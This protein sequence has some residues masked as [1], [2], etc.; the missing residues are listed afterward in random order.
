MFINYIRL[1]KFSGWSRIHLRMDNLLVSVSLTECL[2]LYNKYLLSLQTVL[3]ELNVGQF[4]EYNFDYEILYH[5]LNSEGKFIFVTMGVVYN[6]SRINNSLFVKEYYT[7]HLD[8][9]NS[10]RDLTF[11]YRFRYHLNLKY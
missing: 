2:D 8:K 4:L 11:V 7:K 6:G 9:L 5:G 3:L 10:L 1:H